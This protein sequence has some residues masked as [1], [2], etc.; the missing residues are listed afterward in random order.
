MEPLPSS[1]GRAQHDH[2]VAEDELRMGDAAGL[3]RI[4]RV[5]A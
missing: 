1:D 3:V 4:D 5:A 2:A